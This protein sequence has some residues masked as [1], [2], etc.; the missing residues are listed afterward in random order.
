MSTESG[1]K[2]VVH[3]DTPCPFCALGCDDL[4]VS[5]IE[6]DG[7]GP[8]L[9]VDDVT[10][11]VARQAFTANACGLPACRVDGAE[12]ERREAIRE[13]A[14]HLGEA[15]RVFVVGAGVDIPGSRSVVRLAQRLGAILDTASGE[16]FQRESSS[17]L[18]T[19]AWRTT[20]AEI[21]SRAERILLIGPD[22]TAAAP[23]FFERCVPSSRPALGSRD[24]RVIHLGGIEPPE[25]HKELTHLGIEH[26]PCAGERLAA[27]VGVLR[28]RLG[29]FR[30]SGSALDDDLDTRLGELAEELQGEGY[31]A[32][33]WAPDQLPEPYGD[34]LGE[35][36]DLLVRDLNQSGRAGG[37]PLEGPAG[38]T[39]GQVTTWLTGMPLPVRFLQG[40][41]VVRDPYHWPAQTFLSG[42]GL[43][44]DRDALLWVTPLGAES[45]QSEPSSVDRARQVFLT[46]AAHA[47]KARGNV[48][49]PVGTPGVHHAGA[50][51]RNDEV[52]TLPLRRLWEPTDGE[53]VASL[54]ETLEAIEQEL[55]PC[56]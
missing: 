55:G 51:F 27:A 9:Q 16:R 28:T 43:N 34:L 45:V 42:E 48:V 22:P 25:S 12:V 33:V 10:C 5:R 32:V 38:S 6:G 7:D 35:Q 17:L 3:N 19:G 20:Q 30:Y 13:A 26:I 8:G 29:G 44:P 39:L 24:R 23:R 14:R 54:Q 31:T 15:E 1:S 47:P 4:T 40:Q 18:S 50:A 56:E 37:L 21:K 41:T 2:S 11:P 46:S 36:I 52:V 49:I 53:P